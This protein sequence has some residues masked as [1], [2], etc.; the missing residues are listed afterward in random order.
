MSKGHGPLVA[1]GL[2]IARQYAGIN[3]LCLG[4]SGEGTTLA[5]AAEASNGDLAL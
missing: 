5:V 3:R 4:N 1:G 2:S